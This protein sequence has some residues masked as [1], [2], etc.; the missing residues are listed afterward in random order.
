MARVG[1]LARGVVYRAI[2]RASGGRC[3]PGLRV[4]PRLRLRHGAHQG[5]SFGRN[6]YLGIGTV[7]DCPPGG[8]VSIGDDVT[9]THGIF[10][11]AAKSVKIGNDTLVGEY[12]S[13]RDADHFAELGPVPIREQPMDA[14]GCDIGSNVWIGRGC[15]IL[16]GAVLHDGCVIGANSVVRGEIPENAI[17]VGSPAK[18]RRLRRS[19]GDA[20]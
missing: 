2:I 12:V 13:I 4:E 10:I 6:V 7:I 14:R 15:A 9:L 3:G 8:Q 11:S 18:V 5:L 1:Y 20:L 16:S 19:S 17:A